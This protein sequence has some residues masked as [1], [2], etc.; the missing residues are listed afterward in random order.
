MNKIKNIFTGK[1]FKHGSFSVGLCV[2]VIAIVLV[3]NMVIRLLPDS[4]K[5]IDIS[6][7][8]IYT[9]GEVTEGVVDSLDKDVQIHI[10]AEESKIDDRILKFVQKYTELSD[11][12]SY[13]IIDPVLHPSVL[14]EYNVSQNTIVVECADTGK[15]TSIA[16]TDIIVYDQSSYYYYGQTVEKE[17]DGEGQLTSAVD[18]VTNEN[19]KTV[20]TVEGHGESA[21]GTTASD[22]LDKQNFNVNS[23]NLITEGAIPEDCDLLLINGA[24][25]DF[26]EDEITMLTDYM[27][28]GGKI[29]LLVG[30]T[31]DAMTNLRG[32]MEHYGIKQVDGY[33]ADAERYY[34]QNMYW[35]FPNLS[36]NCDITSDFSTDDLVLLINSRGFELTDPA[37][38]DVTTTEFMTTS[39]NGYAVNGDDQTQGTYVLGAIAEKNIDSETMG[40]LTVLGT[41]T[42]IED[43]IV[44]AFPSLANTSVFMNSITGNFNDVST[45]SIESK[46]LEVSYNTVTSPG[47]IGMIFIAV[48]PLAILIAGFVH[49]MRRRKA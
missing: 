18:Y 32:F 11:K 31:E 20:Y 28:A 6:S 4:I 39:S 25:K 9:I 15:Q 30:D 8:K 22:L 45:I 24:T 10:I 33:I 29:V 38:D 14:N 35:I 44:Q 3:L 7:T 46:S 26:A 48:V 16:F 47:S 23:V 19:T 36:S 5:N 40:C 41:N 13:D 34:Q 21:L 37:D 43:N 17:F 2:V 12:L 49:W 1:K 42:L 27:D